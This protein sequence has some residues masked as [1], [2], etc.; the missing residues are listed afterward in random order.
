MTPTPEECVELL[1]EAG[2]PEDVIEH[3][4]AVQRLAST[5]AER[6][7]VDDD[8]VAAG[9]LLHDVGRAFTHDIDHVPRGLAFLEERGVDERVR[10]CVARH[11]GAGVTDEEADE[12]GWPEGVWTPQ[13]I[14]EKIV[15]HADNLTSGTSYR[16]LDDLIQS[17]HDDDLGHLET[18]M[19]LLHTE[20]TKAVGEDPAVI[21]E[22]MG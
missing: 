4:A 17:L 6:T 20:V 1:Q 9:A 16:G 15:A 18:R 5:L 10:A 12:L 19:R 21:A 22:R 8:V 2:C 7:D 13:R 14:E 11:V 3:A